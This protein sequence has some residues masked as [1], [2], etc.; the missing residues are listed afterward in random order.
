M[1]EGN[2]SLQA[3]IN[4]DDKIDIADFVSILN[5]MAEQ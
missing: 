5:L 2:F 3:D 4:A 1:A